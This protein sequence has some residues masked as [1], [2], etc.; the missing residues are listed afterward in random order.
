MTKPLHDSFYYD[1]LSSFNVKD[2]QYP[3]F[4]PKP[5]SDEELENIIQKAILLSKEMTKNNQS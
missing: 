1:H 2:S 3:E 4:Q 5:L